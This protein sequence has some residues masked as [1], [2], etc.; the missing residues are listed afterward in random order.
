MTAIGVVL[1][2]AAAAIPALVRAS[3]ILELIR[4]SVREDQIDPS[5]VDVTIPVQRRVTRESP[6][7]PI[8]KNGLEP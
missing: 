2:L 6:R 3:R 1:L 8:G 5:P 7:A 4:R